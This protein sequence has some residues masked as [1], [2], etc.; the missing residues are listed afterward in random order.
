MKNCI[1]CNQLTAGSVG[2]AGIRWA[3]ICQ[4]CKDKEDKALEELLILQAKVTAK[5]FETFNY[6]E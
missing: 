2:V 6:G 4:P 3:S 5:I 1:L